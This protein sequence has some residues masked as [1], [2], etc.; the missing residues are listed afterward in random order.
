MDTHS[1]KSDYRA[2][3]ITVTQ[4]DIAIAAIADILRSNDIP[5]IIITRQMN[6]ESCPK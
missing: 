3:L 6:L 2:V 4:M 5:A 1:K